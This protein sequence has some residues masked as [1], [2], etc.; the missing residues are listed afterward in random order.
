V[1]RKFD[2]ATSG[3][4]QAH[5]KTAA[6][7]FGIDFSHFKSR[8]W[9]KNKIFNNRRL[10]AEDILIK[11]TSGNRQKAYLLK[12]GLLESGV[13]YRCKNCGINEWNGRPIVLEI[14]H[15]NKNVLDDRLINL[16]FLCPNCHSQ[17]PT[18]KNKKQG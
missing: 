11:R 10:T 6:I 1:C 17:T 9:S 7:E 12:R 13:E 5:I 2:V 3:G 18:Y 4:I 8:A 14:D 15:I 16:R